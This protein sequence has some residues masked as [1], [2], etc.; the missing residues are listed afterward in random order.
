MILEFL[1]EVGTDG[2]EHVAIDHRAELA[3]REQT[4]RR[5]A[6]PCRCDSPVELCL[7][8]LAVAMPPASVENGI[9]VTLSISI[10][11]RHLNPTPKAQKGAK[12]AS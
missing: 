1:T 6:I 3:V 10:Y 7:S 12:A 9:D 2:T 5:R 11:A 8:H 4:V